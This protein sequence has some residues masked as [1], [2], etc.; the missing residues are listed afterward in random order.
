VIF[1]QTRPDPTTTETVVNTTP[2]ERGKRAVRVAVVNDFEVVVR[3]VAA[4]LEPYRNRIH[5]VELDV[6]EEPHQ[7][8]DVALFD[9]FASPRNSLARA[10]T[11]LKDGAVRHVA[12]YTWETSEQLIATARSIGVSGV[13]GKSWTGER[14][15]CAVEAVAAN[16]QVGL[17]KALPSLANAEALSNREEEILALLVSGCSNREIASELFLSVDTVKTHVRRLFAKLGVT[18][19]AQAAVAAVNG[20]DRRSSSRPL[21]LEC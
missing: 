13:I 16:K 11:M 6:H 1:D 7:R 15:V 21:S 4:M 14:V 18:N 12:L 5:V 9:T 2:A 20:L 10:R 3:G 19:R 8:P 17:T